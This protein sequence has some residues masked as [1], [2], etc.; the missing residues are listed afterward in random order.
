MIQLA[1]NN[2]IYTCISTNG[3][4]MNEDNAGKTVV[5][6]LDRIIISLDGTTPEIYRKYRVKG[7]FH[8]VIQGIK[9]LVEAKKLIKSDTP[10]IILQ[11]IVFRHNQ[12][13][14]KEVI[15]LGKILGV[16][17][18]KL[19]TA[20]LYDFEHGHTMLTDLGSF[21]RYRKAGEEYIIKGKMHNRCRRIW[22]IGVVTTD[23]NMTPCCYDKNAKYSM[24]KLTDNSVRDLWKSPAFMKYRFRLLHNRKTT[25][26]CSNCTE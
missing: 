16:N 7:N 11:F 18:V 25:D 3:H 6:G 14:I 21:A 10:F 5:S 17:K 24:G 23:G 2:N 20:Q 22:T 1:D 13:Q 19:K 26:I 9:N 12:H 4:F 8:E 15:Q